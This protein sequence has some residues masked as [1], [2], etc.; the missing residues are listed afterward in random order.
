MDFTKEINKKDYIL[1]KI[2]KGTDYEKDGKTYHINGITMFLL[3]TDCIAKGIDDYQEIIGKIEQ[4]DGYIETKPFH[5]SYLEIAQPNTGNVINIEVLY[6]LTDKGDEFYRDGKWGYVKASK[7]R[8][9]IENWDFYNKRAVI[10][11]GI[12][13]LLVNILSILYNIYA[14]NKKEKQAFITRTQLDSTMKANG[15]RSNS[16]K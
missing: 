9:W 6:G 15:I 10:I 4:I 2:G 3:T 7:R 1:N 12:A 5:N 8:I 13:A 11:T 16:P 14:G